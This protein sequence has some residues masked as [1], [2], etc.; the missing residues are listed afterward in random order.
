LITGDAVNIAA[1][2][3]QSTTP[4]TILVG[5]RT[6]LNTRDMFTFQTIAPL[7]L[8]GEPEP[9]S[10]HV[11]LGLRTQTPAIPQRPR[12]IVGRQA[13]LV[14]RSLELTLQHANYAR[15]RAERRPH[16]ITIL[17]SSGIGKSR[18]V[19]DFIA[20]E[21]ERARSVSSTE[22]LM[23]PLVLQGRCPPYREGITY[24][25]LIEILRS[26]LDRREDESDEELQAR[27]QLFERELLTRTELRQRAI[28]YLS[29]A[30][31]Q[32]MRSYYTVRA[33]QAYNNTLDLLI[34]NEADAPALCRMYIKL[35]DVHTQRTNLWICFI[36]YV[37]PVMLLRKQINA[38]MI[39]VVHIITSSK[40]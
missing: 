30:R 16:L 24:W 3:Q 5:E 26:L 39:W 11:V 15:V 27:L 29:Q 22:G 25:P 2:L 38:G 7:R 37:L 31:D 6:Y 12:G 14:G 17:G 36:N 33:I 10:A 20:R 19:R 8:K 1:R 35:G 9:V 21:Q 40:L 34:E 23:A 4:D 28:K 13:P 32:A 18:L